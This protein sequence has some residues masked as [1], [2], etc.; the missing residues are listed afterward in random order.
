[1]FDKIARERLKQKVLERWENEGGKIETESKGALGNNPTRGGE[2]K[3]NRSV[4][5]SK[6]PVGTPVSRKSKLKSR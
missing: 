6:N 2:S 5:S 3:A 4:R 1:M